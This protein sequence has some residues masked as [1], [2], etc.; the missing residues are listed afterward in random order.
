MAQTEHFLLPI[1]TIIIAITT[2]LFSVLVGVI[3][4]SCA[5][6]MGFSITYL[7]LI[8]KRKKNNKTRG[9]RRP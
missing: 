5:K 3:S 8:N 1:Q 4:A 2:G 6:S 9:P 7:S